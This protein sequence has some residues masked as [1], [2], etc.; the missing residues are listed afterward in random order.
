MQLDSKEWK[1]IVEKGSKKF[2]IEINPDM[3]QQLSNH[4]I[5]LL[6]WNK[7]MNLTAIK[8]PMDVA[9][10]HVI[11]SIVPSQFISNKSHVLDIGAGG[12]FPGIPVKIMKPDI[13]LT[14]VD[15]SRKKVSFLKH[16]IRFLKFENADAFHVRA[17]SLIDEVNYLNHFDVI[18][19]RA[20]SDLKMFITLALPLLKK[21][22]MLIAMKGSDFDK[23]IIN[24][25]KRSF[26]INNVEA[27]HFKDLNIDIKKYT[28]PFS[29]DCRSLLLIKI[30]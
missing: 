28:L 23:E 21:D 8:D 15:A 19:S 14:M 10:K 16:V 20:F 22:G 26:F 11:D 30:K 13:H 24:I 3:V 9:V 17:E 29:D 25:K 12:G 2:G 5:E 6:K 27:I 7:K 18:I 4:C 1:N